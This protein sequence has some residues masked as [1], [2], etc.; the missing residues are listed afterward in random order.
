M[1]ELAHDKIANLERSDG[2]ANQ[3]ANAA[4]DGFEH[5]PHLTVAAFRDLDLEERAFVFVAQPRDL[6]RT[7]RPV[8]EINAI[9]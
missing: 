9:A 2:G 7:G 6:G 1:P 4:I 5:A 3:F 8:I